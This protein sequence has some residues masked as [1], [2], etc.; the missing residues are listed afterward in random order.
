M[1]LH[2]LQICASQ[3]GTTSTNLTIVTSEA[4]WMLHARDS[5]VIM[6][7]EGALTTKIEADRLTVSTLKEVGLNLAVLPGEALHLL[8]DRVIVELRAREKNALQVISEQK[9]NNVKMSL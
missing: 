1:G 4:T 8:Q 7:L 2:D 9:I 3:T 5:R 6:L